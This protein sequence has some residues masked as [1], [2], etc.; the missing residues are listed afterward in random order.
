MLVKDWMNP[1]PL[2]VQPET[3]LAEAKGMMEKY[4]IRHLLVLADGALVGI[5]S[6]H[7]LQAASLPAGPD[8]PAAAREA[9]LE[10]V[11]VGDAMTK[12]PRTVHPDASLLE[13]ARLILEHR[14]RALPVVDGGRLVGI[15]TETDIVRAFIKLAEPK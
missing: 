10:R 4:W 7:D 5:F 3:P 2:T 8:F 15:I 11:A 9:Q 12:N 6:D 13:A 1:Q 14:F